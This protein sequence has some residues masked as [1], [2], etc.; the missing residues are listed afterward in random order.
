MAHAR[1]LLRRAAAMPAFL[2]L[3]A[4]GGCAY[5]SDTADPA[6]LGD[7]ARPAPWT[8]PAQ[9]SS[10]ETARPWL[11]PTQS[12]RCCGAGSG[13]ITVASEPP[14]ARCTVTR[15]GNRVAEIVT[16]AQVTLVRGNSPAT[17]S[18]SAPGRLTTTATLYPLRDFAVWHHQPRGDRGTA[19]HRRDIE[20]GRVRRFFDTT[21]HLPP[22]RFASAAERDAWFAARAEA[23]R[24]A[25]A[26]PIARARRSAGARYNGMIDSPET[27]TRYM[28]N[29]LAALDALRAQ[30]Q[31]GPA[32]AARGR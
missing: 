1:S 13:V 12:G 20:T 26:E 19:E 27:L 16:P 24:A 25:W 29:D 3:L 6:A 5:W 17:L 31:V 18:C 23:I 14:G 32:T 8:A 10:P 30:A 7:A 2:G 28:Q 11:G 9:D 22:A 4:L 21:V 15:D